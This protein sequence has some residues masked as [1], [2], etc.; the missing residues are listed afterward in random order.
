MLFAALVLLTLAVFINVFKLWSFLGNYTIP[1]FC[2]AVAIGICVI[3]VTSLLT[4][5]S[6]SSI[7]TSLVVLVTTVVSVIVGIGMLIDGL[8]YSFMKDWA[9]S[10]GEWL[11]FTIILFLLFWTPKLMDKKKGN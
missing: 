11:A 5:V 10:I 8:S 1:W 4:G 9:S 6:I 7:P 3:N 2:T